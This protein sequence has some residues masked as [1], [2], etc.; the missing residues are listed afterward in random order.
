[1][2]MICPF[3]AV[4]LETYNTKSHIQYAKINCKWV[5]YK[6]QTNARFTNHGTGKSLKQILIWY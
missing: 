5:E 2:N 1:M 6:W 3:R 4:K